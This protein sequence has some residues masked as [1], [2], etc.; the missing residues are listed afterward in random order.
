MPAG[1][2]LRADTSLVVV[3]RIGLVVLRRPYSEGE[4]GLRFASG[5]TLLV[6][7]Y[8][9]EGTTRVWW[10]GQIALVETFWDRAAMGKDTGA[11]LVREPRREWWAHVMA[12]DPKGVREGWL[13]ATRYRVDGADACGAGTPSAL[14]QRDL[15]NVGAGGAGAEALQHNALRSAEDSKCEG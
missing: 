13:E 9:G 3:T 12:L 6:L 1:T 14:V 10:R 4:G 15:T 5:D 2:K 8:L 11:E 7:D